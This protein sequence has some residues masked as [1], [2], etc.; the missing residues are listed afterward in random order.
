MKAI[1]C[2][3][4]GPPSG[5]EVIEIE[6]PE[7]RKN[8]VLVRVKACGVNFP[9][10]L[11]IQGLYQFKPALPFTP[12]SD[13]AG[14]VKQVGEG[15]THVKAG[16]A[17]FGFVMNGGFAEEVIVPA[18]TCFL[19]PPQ[20]DFPIAA[21]F[22]MAYGTSYHA[23]KDRGHLKEGETLLILGASGG[24]GLAAVELGKLMGAKVIAAASS[25]SKLTLCKKY[26]ADKVINYSE[27]NLKDTIKELTDGK[28][29][30]VVYDPVGGNYS[31]A[32]I[33]GMAWEGRYLIIGFAAG[34]IP[35]IPLNLPLL[36]GC[37]LVGVFWGSFAMKT[38][39]TNQQ[40]TIELMQ[41]YEQGKL[42]PHIHKVYSLEEAPK[43]LEEM[44][45]RK[46]KGKAVIG[47]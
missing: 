37:A 20:M 9:D 30:D 32:A 28:G 45:Q 42:K 13:I 27:E 1:V 22:M 35:K 7:P 4:F 8:E 6:S 10:T 5:L 38:P 40:N 29:V 46:V 14:V 33:R 34:D 43:A 16:D 47:M 26:G 44:M 21:S 12:G 39:K 3:A 31:E 15:V 19:K 36:K 24:V 18:N 23:L 25:K 2:K 17:V 41:W 11:I